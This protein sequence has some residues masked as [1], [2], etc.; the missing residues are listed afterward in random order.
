MSVLQFLYHRIVLV[1]IEIKKV[2]AIC[3]VENQC[4]VLEKGTWWTIA[5]AAAD[6]SVSVQFVII[7]SLS[8][9]SP[10][11]NKPKLSKVVYKVK[12]ISAYF[13][14]T[15]SNER[16]NEKKVVKFGF[17][18]KSS[19]NN[20]FFSPSFA[21]RYLF[22]WLSEE[23]MK[24][25]KVFKMQIQPE[26]KKFLRFFHKQQLEYTPYEKSP[27][28]TIVIKCSNIEICVLLLESEMQRRRRER[29]WCI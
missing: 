24:E 21:R 12:R 20:F 8:F 11:L 10:R 13:P 26:I 28:Y 9:F 4:G 29:S 2:D 16:A 15:P 23:L 18:W 27:V 6:A 22:N 19:K 5:D 17:K 25:V 1:C 3:E 14:T 7:F